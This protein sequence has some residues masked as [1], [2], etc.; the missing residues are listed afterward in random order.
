M[1]DDRPATRSFHPSAFFLHP[2]GE[3]LRF[4]T[5]L[6][7]PG[8]PP[9]SSERSIGRAIPLFPLAGAIVGA[10]LAG[11]GLASGFLWDAWVRAALVVVAWGIITSGLHL[12][13]LADLV[14][15][16]GTLLT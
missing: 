2:L 16:T 7:V 13:G 14:E 10:L 8:M 3:A 4:L 6:P 12:D 11:I 5:I 15:K 1:S 9:T